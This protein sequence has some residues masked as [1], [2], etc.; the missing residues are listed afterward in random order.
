MNQKTKRYVAKTLKGLEN[1]LRDELQELGA[2]KIRVLTRAV[3]FDATKENLYRI[4]YSVRT[5]M[6]ILTPLFSF[7]AGNEREFY[8]KVKAY[9]WHRTFKIKNSFSISHNVKSE[10]FTHSQYISLKMKDAIVDKFR[11]ERGGE[12][13]N[14]DTDNPDLKFNLKINGDKCLVSIDTSGASLFK[15]G[16]RLEVNEAPLNECLAA[17]LILLS[18]WDKKTDLLDPTCGSGTLL[19]EAAM[20]ANDIPSGY[21]RKKFGFM[22]FKDFDVKLWEKVKAECDAKIK[23]NNI[24]V[25]GSDIDEKSIRIAR[26]NVQNLDE[27]RKNIR[28]KNDDAREISQPIGCGQVIFNP[29]YGERLSHDKEVIELYSDIADNLKVNFK[30]CNVSILT[31]NQ[32]AL[33]KFNLSQTASVKVLNGSLDCFFNSYKVS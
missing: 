17:G 14:V 10:I 11:E 2:E 6:S 21:Y 1:V 33:A 15:R 9:H 23:S 16:Y 13:P 25:Y 26:N 8:K 19:I 32:D 4:N 27:I 22:S 3:E 7:S 20:I 30:N 29:P 31:S 18:G 28:I 24:K 5:A 12:R